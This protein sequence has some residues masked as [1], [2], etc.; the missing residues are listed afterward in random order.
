MK[1]V[2]SEIV[3][4]AVRPQQYPADNLAEVAF[5]GRSNVG[6]S[7]LLN[8]ITGRKNLARVSASPGKTQT[9]N[10]YLVN[11][12]HDPFRIVDLPGYGYAKVSKKV[13]Q[14]W[15]E[16]METFLTGRQ[17]LRKVFQLVDIRHK[18]TVQDVQMYNFLK[19]YDLDGPVIA[20]KADKVSKREAQK[21]MQIIRKTLDM[22]QDAA[23]LPVSAL[24]KTGVDQ[25]LAAIEEIVRIG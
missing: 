14:D 2:Q 24:K 13:T 22:R 4:T 6:K 11:K 10:F 5:A 18:P 1:I 8:L 16:M 20:T 7:S 15:G 17:G 9:I 19:Y 23:I 25:V 3:A 12:D 21:Q